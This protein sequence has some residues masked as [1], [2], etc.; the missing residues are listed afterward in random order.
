MHRRNYDPLS[1]TSSGGGFFESLGNGIGYALALFILG[2]LCCEHKLG[3]TNALVLGGCLLLLAFYGAVGYGLVAMGWWVPSAIWSLV[4]GFFSLVGGFFSTLGSLFSG[5]FSLVIG[6]V[7]I[8]GFL[9][10]SGNL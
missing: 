5:A 7:V 2:V 4:G 9:S 1:V 6:G 8:L 10:C 3:L